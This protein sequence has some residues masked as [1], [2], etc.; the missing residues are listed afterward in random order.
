[1]SIYAMH[2][3][4]NVFPEPEAF[5]PE[6]WVGQYDRYMDR[7]FV[8]FT[9]GSRS[10][11]GIKAHNLHLKEVT[12]WIFASFSLA[13]AELYLASAMLFR[14]G[15]PKLVL[16]NADESDI[17]ISRDYIMGFARADAKDIRIKVE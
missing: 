6:R 3:D 16:H 14:P 2:F 7:N 9:K 1:M 10:C 8:P 12:D 15:G 4:P 5:K 11:L 13:W 17:K